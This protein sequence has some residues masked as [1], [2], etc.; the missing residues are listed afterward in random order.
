MESFKDYKR[1]LHI[2]A[3]PVAYESILDISAI[4]CK[5]IEIGDGT[6]YKFV[7]IL[8]KKAGTDDS[9]PAFLH[10]ASFSNIGKSAE[11]IWVVTA[12]MAPTS[13]AFPLK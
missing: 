3:V 5:E 12:A 4:H 11:K 13:G 2:G 8:Q 10:Q 9:F 1:V 6:E 7:L